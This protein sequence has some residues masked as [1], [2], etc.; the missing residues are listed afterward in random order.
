MLFKTSKDL[1]NYTYYLERIDSSSTPIE[2]PDPWTLLASW[3]AST[4]PV[5]YA[6][7]GQNYNALYVGNTPIA[8]S[9]QWPEIIGQYYR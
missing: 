3:K 5:K 9:A 7:D 8:I 6:Q 2:E 4:G 1:K